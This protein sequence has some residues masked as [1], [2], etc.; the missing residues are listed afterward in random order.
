MLLVKTL[1]FS[2][3]KK[4]LCKK[5]KVLPNEG[6]YML[7][8]FHN[9]EFNKDYDRAIKV[10]SF[11]NF[12]RDPTGDLPWDEDETAQDVMHIPDNVVSA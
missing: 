6:E 2:E 4:K 3:T 7:K 10:T 5:A 11:V 9:G 8:H 1:T 12:L